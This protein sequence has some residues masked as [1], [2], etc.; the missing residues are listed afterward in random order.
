MSPAFWLSLTCLV[1]TSE[2]SSLDESFLTSFSWRDNLTKLEVTLLKI[3]PCLRNSSP[4]TPPCP[5]NSSRRNPPSPSKFWDAARGMGMDIFWIHPMIGSSSQYKTLT[6]ILSRY[7][8]CHTWR[9]ILEVKYNINNIIY[10]L[11]TDSIFYNFYKGSEVKKFKCYTIL[12]HSPQLI[13]KETVTW[14]RVQ[15]LKE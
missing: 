13:K 1:H 15:I 10:K 6:C 12:N 9:L 11:S 3:P 4:I 14:Q 5:Q 7:R 8:R 2:S